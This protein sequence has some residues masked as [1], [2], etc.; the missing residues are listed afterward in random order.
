MSLYRLTP[1]HP[2]QWLTHRVHAHHCC[3]KDLPDADTNRKCRPPPKKKEKRKKQKPNLFTWKCDRLSLQLNA[4]VREWYFICVPHSSAAHRETGPLAR[5]T[6]MWWIC[7]QGHPCLYIM[8]LGLWL[9]LLSLLKWNPQTMHD[10]SSPL[11]LLLVHQIWAWK[12]VFD[13][14]NLEKDNV[15]SIRVISGLHSSCF[16][17]RFL[18]VQPQVLH[19]SE[20]KTTKF[21]T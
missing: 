13:A 4:M 5:C 15:T 6:V 2:K 3:V 19:Q 12:N 18:P 7:K 1:Q 9:C 11:Y 16:S 17:S 8:I 21:L 14:I 20:D 10:S